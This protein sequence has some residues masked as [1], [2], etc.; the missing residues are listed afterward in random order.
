MELLWDPLLWNLMQPCCLSPLAGEAHTQNPLPA[1]PHVHLFTSSPIRC[2]WSVAGVNWGPVTSVAPDLLSC[3]LFLVRKPWPLKRKPSA[4]LMGAAHVTTTG[5]RGGGAGLKVCRPHRELL[6]W[7]MQMTATS[8]HL[9]SQTARPS[10]DTWPRSSTTM[11]KQRLR[12][13][14]RSKD[15]Y[16]K[17]RLT[18][19]AL[20]WNQT[21]G[22]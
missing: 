1:H 16:G 8:R 17:S 6:W 9:G 19:P 18:K 13:R 15:S 11:M 2:C 5:S 10:L 12:W 20:L 22:N 7:S 3:F 4:P 21:F 14:T